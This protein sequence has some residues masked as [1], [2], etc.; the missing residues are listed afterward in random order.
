M[1]GFAVQWE[2]QCHRPTLWD[3][4]GSFSHKPWMPWGFGGV[5]HWHLMAPRVNP[6]IKGTHPRKN[7]PHWCG[8]HVLYISCGWCCTTDW[9]D[10]HY[11]KKNIKT[12]DVLRAKIFHMSLSK[13]NPES[14]AV[15]SFS[16]GTSF[17]WCMLESPSP[18][19]AHVYRGSHLQ[20]IFS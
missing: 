11:E 16:L 13:S 14:T 4:L 7:P 8:W 10:G 3:I 19:E 18:V 17:A 6:T 15:S 5:L 9:F 2:T 12:W 1:L 20:M